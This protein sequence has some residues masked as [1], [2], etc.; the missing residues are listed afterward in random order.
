MSENQDYLQAQKYSLSQGSNQ[1]DDEI[2]LIDVAIALAKH[3]KI[4]LGVPLIVAMITAVI[5]LFIPNTY[6]A[7]T[8]ILLSGGVVPK[9]VV[10]SILESRAMSDSLIKAFKLKDHYNVSDDWKA[11]KL[12]KKLVNIGIDN[13]VMLNISVTDT[14]PQIAVKMVQAYGQNLKSFIR[15]YNFTESSRKRIYLERQLPEIQKSLEEAQM[16]LKV[17]EQSSDRDSSDFQ[18][19]TIIKKSAEIKAKI[20]MKELELQSMQSLNMT[21]NPNYLRAQEELNA[22]WIEFGKDAQSDVATS[23]ISIK[24]NGYLKSLKN[25]QYAET[26]YEQLLKQIEKAKL[27][28]KFDIPVIQEVSAVEVPHEKS[29]P[30]RLL[31]IVLSAVTS[32]FISV[33]W[34]LFT[35]A[36]VNARN[37]LRNKGRIEMLKQALK[38]Q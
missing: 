26:R 13:N 34:A 22:L 9:E 7:T 3:K 17:D 27:D 4:I 10:V 24:E 16:K 37:D 8:N 32:F 19:I 36:M 28:E 33:L 6:K 14:D 31:I 35:E 15:I 1:I 21:A 5:T 23:R 11:R 30:K 38:W 2:S 18:V 12:L 20:A 25:F 29:G